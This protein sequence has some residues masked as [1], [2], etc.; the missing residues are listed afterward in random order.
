M[1]KF[2]KSGHLFAW[3]GDFP[4]ELPNE[5]SPY[6][7]KLDVAKEIFCFTENRKLMLNQLELYYSKINTL[8]RRNNLVFGGG[9]FFSRK[10]N[11]KDIDIFLVNLSSFPLNQDSLRFE[12]PIVQTFLVQ[13]KSP[14]E[15]VFQTAW[16]SSRFSCSKEKNIR[17]FVQLIE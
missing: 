2:G 3:N 17:G 9:S 8:T 16:W 6:R 14:Q 4:S 10:Y 5:S 11:P 13:N 12:F 1:L 7:L 15:I